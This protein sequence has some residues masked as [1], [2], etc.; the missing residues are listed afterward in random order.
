[1]VRFLKE[2]YTIMINPN[3]PFYVL[4]PLEE[5]YEQMEQAVVDASEYDFPFT[6][7]DFADFVEDVVSTVLPSIIV[8]GFNSA[9]QKAQFF[10]GPSDAID[11]VNTLRQDISIQVRHLQ[12]PIYPVAGFVYRFYITGDLNLHVHYESNFPQVNL[13][14][15]HTRDDILAAIENGDF[16]SEKLKRSYGIY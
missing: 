4:L 1:M 15:T 13:Q 12:L 6:I 10:V 9:I 5:A 8:D 7:K 11:L 3:L 16:I 2:P 14:Q